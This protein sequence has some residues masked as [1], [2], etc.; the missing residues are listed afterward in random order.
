MT[1]SPIRITFLAPGHLDHG[2]LQ[3]C[4]LMP[5]AAL[6][7][8]REFGQGGVK[9]ICASLRHYPGH[10]GSCAAS[11]CRLVTW[12]RIPAATTSRKAGVW[13]VQ[14]YSARNSC[15]RPGRPVEVGEALPCQEYNRSGPGIQAEKV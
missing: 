9:G 12:A 5:E 14:P 15:S 4:P 11:S 13:P 10:S 1:E 2:C 6:C 7:E 3:T 8:V